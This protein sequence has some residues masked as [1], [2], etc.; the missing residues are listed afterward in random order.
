MAHTPRS[1]KKLTNR[2]RRIRGQLNAVETAIQNDEDCSAVL[3]TLSA[4]RGGLNALIVELIEEHV[5]DHI[6]DPD[7]KPGSARAD[8]TQE[9]LN[10]IRSYF[11]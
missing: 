3:L 8:A 11:K 9:L 7:Q 1:Q 10:V 6:V 4:C 2:V 5:R